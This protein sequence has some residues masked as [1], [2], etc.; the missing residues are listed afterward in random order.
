MRDGQGGCWAVVTVPFD[1]KKG[2]N[3]KGKTPKSH[4][5]GCDVAVAPR[6]D[7]PVLVDV[8]EGVP[9]HPPHVYRIGRVGREPACLKIAGVDVSAGRLHRSPLFF[10]DEIVPRTQRL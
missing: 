1:Q 8:V 10:D 3:R 2:G 7:Q 5:A 9:G 6:H 4:L